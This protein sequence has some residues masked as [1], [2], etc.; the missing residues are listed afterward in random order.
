[1]RQRYRINQRLLIINL[2]VVDGA[3]LRWQQIEVGIQQ[4]NY[5]FVAR[6]DKKG[7]IDTGFELRTPAS[8]DRA[9]LDTLQFEII[10]EQLQHAVRKAFIRRDGADEVNPGSRWE[11]QDRKSVV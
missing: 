9:R 4:F 1:P 3:E 5:R 2:D 8:G 11:A 6:F 7:V 10:A